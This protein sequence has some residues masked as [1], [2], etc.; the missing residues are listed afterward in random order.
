MTFFYENDYT[1][2]DGDALCTLAG[3]SEGIKMQLQG[4]EREEQRSVSMM[5]GQN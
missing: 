5:G 3:V 2:T 1:T 4:S